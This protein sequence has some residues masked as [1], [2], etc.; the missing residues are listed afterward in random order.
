MFIFHFRL[1]KDDA[2][3]DVAPVTQ[4][5]QPKSESSSELK[6]GPSCK[7]ITIVFH[8]VLASYFKFEKEHGDRIVMRFKGCHFG[9]FKHDVVQ[10]QPVRYFNCHPRK[11]GL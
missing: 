1:D 11:Q 9:D 8:A 3:K 7:K 4:D 2:N 5:K 6:Y 10:V